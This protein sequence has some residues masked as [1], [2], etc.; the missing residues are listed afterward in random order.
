M[1]SFSTDA[2]QR[3]TIVREDVPVG[4]LHALSTATANTWV[5][6]LPHGNDAQIVT[7]EPKQ[8]N[9]G[10]LRADVLTLKGWKLKILNAG[11]S[12]DYRIINYVS[13]NIVLEKGID[14]YETLPSGSIE[15]VL[16][17]EVI[18][19]LGVTLHPDATDDVELG[20]T[21][22]DAYTP[23]RILPY[24]FVQAGRFSYFQTKHV[25]KLFYRF[26][27]VS[28]SFKGDMYWGEHYTS[29]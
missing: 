6:F 19:P 9:V 3:A 18:L 15:Y 1:N 17:P 24:S 12:L 29:S 20:F 11:R 16:F 23:S 13:P 25:D 26:P 28:G 5:R 8:L 7:D 2:N 22:E 27:S 10:S 14:N 21:D 4:G